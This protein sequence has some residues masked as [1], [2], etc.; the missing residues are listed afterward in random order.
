MKSQTQANP[1]SLRPEQTNQGLPRP[2][3]TES[4]EQLVEQAAEAA[5]LPADALPDD[6]AEVRSSGFSL[7]DKF[8]N[9]KSLASFGIAFAILGLAFWRADINLAEMWQ[10]ILQ[11][12]LWLYSAGFIVFYGLFPIRAWRWRIILALRLI[13]RNHVKIGR[14]LRH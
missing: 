3:E 11:T 2:A 13:A 5:P 1:A 7:R 12:N 9:V 8:L 14:G 4:L 10:Q 6:L